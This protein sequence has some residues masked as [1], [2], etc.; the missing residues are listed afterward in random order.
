MADLNI[1]QQAI[2]LSNKVWQLVDSLTSRDPVKPW[3]V[4]ELQKIAVTESAEQTVWKKT[5]LGLVRF[6]SF[7]IWS[8][9]I[10]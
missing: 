2:E 9:S 7:T 3:F 10:V 5:T 1:Q 4:V 8:F 6:V